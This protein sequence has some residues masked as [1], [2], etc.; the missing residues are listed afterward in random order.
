MTAAPARQR[1]KFL[2]IQFGGLEEFTLSTGA[3]KAIRE[4]LKDH[5]LTLLTTEPFV[6]L[7]KLSGYF[8]DV[9]ADPLYDPFTQPIRYLDFMKVLRKAGF[10]GVFDLM[11]INRT[12]WYFRQ[13]GRKKP[14]WN[15]AVDWASHPYINPLRSEMHYNDWLDEQLA[16]AGITNIP[17][18]DVSWLKGDI[19]KYDLPKDFV[20]LF[21]GGRDYAFTR[22]NAETQEEIELPPRWRGEN[23]AE[24]VE[25]LNGRG[26][27]PVF[28]GAEDETALVAE[29]VR[30]C[31]S[32]R[33]INLVS[34]VGIADIVEMSRH[35]KMALGNDNEAMWPI[36]AAG[37]PILLIFPALVHFRNR[38]PRNLKVR[39]LE[40]ADLDLLTSREVIRTCG[41]LME[42]DMTAESAKPAESGGAV[43]PETKESARAT[44]SGPT[45]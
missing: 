43:P 36:A 1:R 9:V 23:F 32:Q 44:G 27:T 3:F 18:P 25:W 5:H 17:A 20:M 6:D 15:G 16:V 21:P 29:T 8:N 7:G 39:V 24:V 22:R 13:M 34:K 41:E 42:L 35:A 38:V 30:L 45:V 11:A 19:A 2:V 14:D 33:V 40:Q 37:C 28:M 12:N 26:I 31:G 10:S 4:K